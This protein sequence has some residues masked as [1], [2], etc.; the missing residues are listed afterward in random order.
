MTIV[1]TILDFYSSLH[2]SWWELHFLRFTKGRRLISK[3]YWYIFNPFIQA[4][5]LD[6]H[7]KK[8]FVVV[9]DQWLILI[10][11][12]AQGKTIVNLII[13]LENYPHKNRLI[14]CR[15]LRIVQWTNWH[16]ILPSDR[17][18]HIQIQYGKRK[19]LEHQEQ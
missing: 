19:S 5:Y 11:I 7:L 1:S 4:E 8:I 2:W 12:I 17:K 15:V 6:L 14:S 9:R 3:T 18:F 10:Q 16:K 13:G